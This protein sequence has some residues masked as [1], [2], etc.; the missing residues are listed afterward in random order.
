MKTV[1]ID[2]NY[3]RLEQIQCLEKRREC[4]WPTTYWVHFKD[5][6]KIQIDTGVYYTLSIEM[7]KLINLGEE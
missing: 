6:D 1:E 4:D 7:N 2:G 5:G 3:F